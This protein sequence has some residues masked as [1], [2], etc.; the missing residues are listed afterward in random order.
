MGASLRRFPFP[1]RFQA[2]HRLRVVQT[3]AGG[4]E[5]G[6]WSVAEMRVFDPRGGSRDPSLEGAHHAN[7]WN[8]A[9]AFG[10]NP[11]TR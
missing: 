7:P 9:F 1:F 5:D 10:N 4:P 8:I 6:G 3:A 2:V 11:P